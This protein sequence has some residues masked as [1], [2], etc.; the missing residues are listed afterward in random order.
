MNYPQPPKVDTSN[1][2]SYQ[3]TLSDRTQPT[4]EASPAEFERPDAI[5][6]SIPDY[7]GLEG[8]LSE[9]TRMPFI[10]KVYGILFAQLLVTAMWIG[11]VSLHREFF[12]NFFRVQIPLL[13]V[14]VVLELVC[15]YALGCYRSV[16]RS[17]P[18]NYI[19]LSIFTFSFS[20]TASYSTILY[21][22]SEIFA[23]AFLTAA[24][25]GGLT[26][27]AIFTKTDFSF[28]FAFIWGMSLVLLA[29]FIVAIFMRNRFI[30]LLLSVLVITIVCLFIIYDT[31]MIIGEKSSQFSIDD[32]IFAAMVLY[33]DI[34]RLFLEILRVLGKK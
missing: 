21:D 32:Y 25:V 11:F 13:I 24:L 26:L 16:A 20:Y 19:L 5:H 12:M 4:F 34:M 6:Q 15:L 27:Y 23:A 7:E 3:N 1:E 33:I 28:L 2:K 14:A 18:T 29:T 31:Q 10:R 30:S 22:P 17:V 8:K 9:S